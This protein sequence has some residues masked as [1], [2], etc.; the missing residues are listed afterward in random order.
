MEETVNC[1]RC[2]G[3]VTKGDTFCKHCGADLSYLNLAPQ[4]G[5]SEPKSELSPSPAE[6]APPPPPYERK[7]TMFQRFY[8]LIVSP[9]EAMAD[10]ASAPDYSGV[11]VLLML[12]IVIASV[13][14]WAIMQKFQLIGAQSSVSM[15]WSIISGALVVAMI[16]SGL[17]FLVFWIVKSL[18][19]KLFCEAGSKWSFR[20]AAAV[21]GY[22]Y[23][24]DVI[25]VS[26][27]GIVIAWFTLP[28]LVIDISSEAAA[29][30]AMAQYQ[31]MLSQRLLYAIPVSLLGLLWKSYLGGIGAHFGTGKRCSRSMGIF[32]FFILGFIGFLISQIGRLGV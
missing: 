9:Q 32:V 27:I 16:I 13:A 2:G 20:T 10:I 25:I 14:V 6:Q 21:T 7:F 29:T 22:A 1:P 5:F 26:I 23:I 4:G 31:A 17:L 12:E 15:I 19:V 3:P 24:A 18:L 30:Q 28:T 11:V 8:K